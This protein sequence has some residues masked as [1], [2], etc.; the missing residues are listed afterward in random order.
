MR[1]NGSM[2]VTCPACATKPGAS[3]PPFS[4]RP[5]TSPSQQ[6]EQRIRRIAF[7]YDNV[8]RREPDLLCA[9]YKPLQLVVAEIGENFDF[10]QRGFGSLL[11]RDFLR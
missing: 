3:P 7:V 6:N 10:P 5:R 4:R 9:G 8:P 1:E 2:P 11:L